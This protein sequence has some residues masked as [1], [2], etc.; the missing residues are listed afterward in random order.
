MTTVE[1]PW[2]VK[3]NVV[4]VPAGPPPITATSASWFTLGFNVLRSLLDDKS[5]LVPVVNHIKRVVDMM[6]DPGTLLSTGFGKDIVGTLGRPPRQLVF[7][8]AIEKIRLPGNGHL[9]REIS[10]FKVGLIEPEGF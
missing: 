5:K 3:A 2:C 10:G 1:W 7:L 9:L 8:C 6:P 4:A